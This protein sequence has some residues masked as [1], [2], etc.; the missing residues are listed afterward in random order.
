MTGQ[1]RKNSLLVSFENLSPPG[2]RKS[3]YDTPYIDFI[4]PSN[5]PTDD[6]STYVDELLQYSARKF[7][8]F[9]PFK[10]NVTE[11]TILDDAEYFMGKKECD[12]GMC[13]CCQSEKKLLT[14]WM[15]IEEIIENDPEIIFDSDD[16]PIVVEPVKESTFM[17]SGTSLVGV[18]KKLNL[19]KMPALFK[20]NCSNIP[21]T[22]S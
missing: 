7:S 12:Y 15:S 1:R 14:N 5:V 2:S 9:Q 18:T 16:N 21:D 4:D 17:S 3:S 13:E 8:I 22:V 11:R 20:T 6:D 10:N 19:E